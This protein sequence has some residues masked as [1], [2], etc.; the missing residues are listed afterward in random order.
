ML[1]WTMLFGEGYEQQATIMEPTGGMDAVAHAFYRRTR[2]FIT[3]DAQVTALRRLGSGAR[4]TWRDRAT[5]R[6]STWD[7]DHVIVTVPLPVVSSIDNDLS[8]KVKAAVGAG[9]RVYLPAVKT[10]FQAQRRWW[11]RDHGIYG[12]I[13]WT[14]RDITQVWYPS[15]GI[16]GR[17]GIL[18]G[19]YI[20]SHRPRPLRLGGLGE[21]ALCSN[22][23]RPT[24]PPGAPT[25]AP[26]E[27]GNRRLRPAGGDEGQVMR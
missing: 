2:R 26:A 23:S 6:V 12:G 7:A 15:A 14:T 1:R 16:H 10:A 3:L 9:A 18:V 4:V 20:W 24:S 17:K 13:S 11:E 21:H 8:P 22:A 19:A 27:P 5:G 25:P